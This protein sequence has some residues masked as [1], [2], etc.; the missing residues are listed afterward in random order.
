[1]RIG[2]YDRI[3][4]ASLVLPVQLY[5]GTNNRIAKQKLAVPTFVLVEIVE[6]GMSRI[7]IWNFR[8]FVE[9]QILISKQKLHN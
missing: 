1:M 4:S 6:I 5:Y 8:V 2:F 3:A 7:S 9:M